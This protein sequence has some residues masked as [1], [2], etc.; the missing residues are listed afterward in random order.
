[1]V[2][3]HR[4]FCWAGLFAV[5]ML[6]GCGG[7]PQSSVS[8]KVTTGGAPV[9]GARINFIHAKS[10]TAASA[11]LNDAGEYLI[12]EGLPPGSY[13]VFVTQASASN[14]PPMPGEAVAAGPKFNVPVQ[15]TSDATSPLNF[16]VQAGE[17]K[18]ADF[19]LD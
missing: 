19:K 7:A 18:G 4:W 13:K 9:T 16:E 15:Y 11:D 6:V 10:A 1:M 3:C 14:R 2:R 12:R 5:I 17:N 8:G